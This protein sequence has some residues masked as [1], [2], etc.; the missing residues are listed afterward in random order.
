MI[1][2]I[3]IIAVMRIVALGVFKR[4]RRRTS[5]LAAD[6]GWSPCWSKGGARVEYGEEKTG[7]KGDNAINDHEA[8]LAL[9][10]GACGAGCHLC[11]SDD[12]VY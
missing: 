6:R 2:D 7:D 9:E 8:R 10:E 4:R 11:E 12:G 1:F 5:L 3:G